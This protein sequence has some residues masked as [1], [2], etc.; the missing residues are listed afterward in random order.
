M[1]DLPC[2]S[3]A[4][5]MQMLGPNPEFFLDPGADVAGDLLGGVHV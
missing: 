1:S 4:G 5:S 3:K 2:I